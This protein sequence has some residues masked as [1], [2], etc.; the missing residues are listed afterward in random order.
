MLLPKLI[1]RNW[2]KKFV[3]FTNFT[4]HEI[5]LLSMQTNLPDKLESSKKLEKDK[6]KKTTK[7]TT[8][9][10]L[11]DLENDPVFRAYFFI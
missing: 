1:L 9:K 7:P 4:S 3:P 10:M 6:I 11:E 5:Q 2:P 8:D